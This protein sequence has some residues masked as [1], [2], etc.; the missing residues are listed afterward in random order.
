MLTGV[1]LRDTERCLQACVKLWQRIK[2]KYI[3]LKLS[4]RGSFIYDGTFCEFVPSYN[5]TA[6]DTTGAGDAFTASLT[7]EYLRSKNIIKA[8]K[9]ANAVGA[10]TVS[11][12]GVVESLPD[13]RRVERFMVSQ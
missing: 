2:T 10:L 12:L 9:Y 4:D 8:C 6:Q 13:R 1:E 3:V 11:K 7:L 5:V